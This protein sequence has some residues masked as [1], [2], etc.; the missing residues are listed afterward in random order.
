MTV[1]ARVAVQNTL[2]Q[3]LA[4]D[5][6]SPAMTV[7]RFLRQHGRLLAGGEPGKLADPRLV[8]DLRAG[9][10]LRRETEC[11]LQAYLVTCEHELSS[12]PRLSRN[13]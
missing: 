9:R 7:S 1:D 12:V 4:R 6:G 2:V 13:V 8:L 11:H 3:M 10:R 5:T